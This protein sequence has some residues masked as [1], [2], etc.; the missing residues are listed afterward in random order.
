M[1][2]SLMRM[3]WRIYSKLRMRLPTHPGAA[4]LSVR[5]GAI[6]FEHIE[7][8]FRPERPIL[9]NF[10][11]E[12]PGKQKVALVG[13]S[14]A[15]KST[16]TKLLLRLYNLTEGSISIDGQN[17]AKITQASLRENIAFVPQEPVLFHRSLM[18]NIRYGKRDATDAEVIEAAKQAHCHEFISALPGSYDTFVGER[19]IKLSGGE[20]QRVAIARALLKNAPILL[21]DEATSSLDSES[22]ALIQDA[23]KNLMRGKTVIVIAHR[24]STIMNMDRIVVLEG[25]NIVA[26]GTHNELL[27]RGGLYK[28]LWG[29]QAGGFIADDGEK[30][31]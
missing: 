23:L 19:G 25:G 1:M 27:Q 15:G 3:K 6:A 8:T 9:H 21:L 5:E 18:D 28:K 13:P 24:L 14:G 10:N 12:I 26:D 17:I 29:I 22:E 31:E 30:T 11:L 16:L 20:R 2:H 7:F 4:A